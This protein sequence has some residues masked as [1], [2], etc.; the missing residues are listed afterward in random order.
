MKVLTLVLA[1]CLSGSALSQ[2]IAPDSFSDTVG[3]LNAIT[4]ET[5]EDGE[6][7]QTSEEPQDVQEKQYWDDK[8]REEQEWD[9]NKEL[10]YRYDV[11][12]P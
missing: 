9:K 5:K 4:P 3:S 6:K 2:R 10:D 7:L 11:P 1:L 12:G 8:K